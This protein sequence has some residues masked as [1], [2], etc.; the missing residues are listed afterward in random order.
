MNFIFCGSFNDVLSLDKMWEG[1]RLTT[2]MALHSLV[3]E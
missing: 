3:Q 2:L 1:R